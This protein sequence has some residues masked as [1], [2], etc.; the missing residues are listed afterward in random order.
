M[1]EKIS[2]TFKMQATGGP[3]IT[4]ADT[5]DLET[6]VKTSV[7]V[8]NG[9]PV[10]VAFVASPT[11]LAVTSS[12]YKDGGSVVTYKVNGAGADKN[13]DGPLV[14]IGADN[15]KLVDAALASLTFSNP[16]A[17]PITIEVFSGKDI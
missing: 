17:D 2:W 8:T 5:L 1:A 15:I 16:F 11:L 6:Y 12:K 4:A 14:F 3:T 9:T 13:L 7:T 10:D